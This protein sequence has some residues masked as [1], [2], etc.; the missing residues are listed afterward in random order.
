MIIEE[1]N[2]NRNLKNRKSKKSVKNLMRTQV[3]ADYTFLHMRGALLTESMSENVTNSVQDFQTHSHFDAQNVEMSHA[4]TMCTFSLV[5][6]QIRS[7]Q[8]WYGARIPM[9]H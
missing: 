4:E 5:F 9:Y 8:L 3:V 2:E 6:S 7:M 1:E